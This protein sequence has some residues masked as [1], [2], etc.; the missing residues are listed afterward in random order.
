[1]LTNKENGN[2]CIEP[3]QNNADCQQTFAWSQLKRPEQTQIH[4]QQKRAGRLE[5]SL[6][7]LRVER[8]IDWKGCTPA[9]VK[10]RLGVPAGFLKY[11]CKIWLKSLLSLLLLSSLALWLLRHS[12]YHRNPRCFSSECHCLFALLHHVLPGIDE[13][14]TGESVILSSKLGDVYVWRVVGEQGVAAGS[15]A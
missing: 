12:S 14:N 3:M 10:R 9:E 6:L 4:G 13:P 11:R 1:M 7:A 2:S 15:Y 8:H 5:A